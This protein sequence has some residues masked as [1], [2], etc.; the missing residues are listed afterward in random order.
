MS[1]VDCI[2][3]ELMALN[4][5]DNLTKSDFIIQLLIEN[6]RLR[7]QLEESN[8]SPLRSNFLNVQ[9]LLKSPPSPKTSFSITNEETFF[10]ICSFM[11]ALNTP[12][13]IADAEG[14]IIYFNETCRQI[15]GYSLDKVKG[16]VCTLAVHDG[17]CEGYYSGSAPA[18]YSDNRWVTSDGRLYQ[19]FWLKSIFTG[20][21]GDVVLLIAIG[22]D[23]TEQNVMEEALR[24]SEERYRKLA[25][26]LGSI[27]LPQS[28]ER[29]SKIFHNSPDMMAIVR[30]YDDRFIEINQRF[31]DVTGYTRKELQS[32]AMKEQYLWLNNSDNLAHFPS[33][34]FQR[35]LL[36]TWKLTLRLKAKN[37]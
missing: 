26:K 13:L 10:M 33:S 23:I 20:D 37:H 29:F 15:T 28:E 34:S 16:N 3:E 35:V 24:E 18:G 22:L 4:K 5:G 2:N 32:P 25:E 12:I 36:T 11:D 6:A 14:R 7:Q 21:S 19:V 27:D 30:V 17:D 8:I 9:G 1:R 31:L